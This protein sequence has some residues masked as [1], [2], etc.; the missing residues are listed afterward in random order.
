ML[1]FLCV[2]ELSL[3]VFMVLLRVKKYHHS[4]FQFSKAVDD[5][6]SVIALEKRCLV[7]HRMAVA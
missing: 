2:G 3:C 6:E 7:A 5:I 1:S 4:S